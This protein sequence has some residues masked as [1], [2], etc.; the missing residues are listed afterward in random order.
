MIS[1]LICHFDLP[2]CPAGDTLT[3]GCKNVIVV[4]LGTRFCESTAGAAEFFGTL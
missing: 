2:E 4:I 3:M 1:R